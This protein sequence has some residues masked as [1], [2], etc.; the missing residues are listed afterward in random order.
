M[1]HQ[2]L[3]RLIVLA[4]KWVPRDHHDWEELENMGWEQ[5]DAIGEEVKVGS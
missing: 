3:Q 5:M 1:G 2:N 4:M